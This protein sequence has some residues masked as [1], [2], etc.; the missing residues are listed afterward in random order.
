Y[1][2]FPQ[3]F[4]DLA[5]TIEPPTSANDGLRLVD[6]VTYWLAYLHFGR[7]GN[8]GI[9]WCGRGL[10]DSTTKAL[11]AFFGLA[12]AALFITGAIMWWNRVLRR[13][14]LLERKRASRRR[15]G[16]LTEPSRVLHSSKSAS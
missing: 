14:M 6:Q 1:L 9:P 11:W 8:R 4:Q 13:G 7:L 10:C 2:C 16:R 15:R 3:F 5:D 12:P